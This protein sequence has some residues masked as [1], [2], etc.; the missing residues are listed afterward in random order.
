MRMMVATERMPWTWVSDYC[1]GVWEATATTGASNVGSSKT[2]LEALSD[3]VFAIAITLFVLDIATIM[4]FSLGLRWLPCMK[5][6]RQ[7]G[8]SV[9]I[10]PS[11]W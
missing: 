9:P 7:A 5:R 2:R 1:P 10:S 4:Q 6:V 3:G 8:R 11:P